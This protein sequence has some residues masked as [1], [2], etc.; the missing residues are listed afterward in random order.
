MIRVVMAG[1]AALLSLA[2]GGENAAHAEAVEHDGV[3][4]QRE[5]GAVRRYDLEADSW[6]ADMTLPATLHH[7]TAD[8]S[9][10]WV[11]ESQSGGGV[12]KAYPV[13]GGAPLWEASPSGDLV[14]ISPWLIRIHGLQLDVLDKGTGEVID[15]VEL[16]GYVQGFVADPVSRR[17]FFRFMGLASVEVGEDGALGALQ[18]SGGLVP[19][20]DLLRALPGRGVVVDEF[21]TMFD[22]ATLAYAGRLVVSSRILAVAEVG[23]EIVAHL[24]DGE[25][26]R[27]GNDLAELG[28]GEIP[29]TFDWLAP[30]NGDAVRL[31]EVGGTSV[32]PLDDLT[33]RSP[34]P[35][36]SGAGAFRPALIESGP[37]GIVLLYARGNLLRWSHADRAYL[38]GIP[39]L[40]EPKSISFDPDRGWAVIANSD[41]RISYVDLASLDPQERFLTST[42]WFN[43]AVVAGSFVVALRHHLLF[44]LDFSGGLLSE[45]QLEGLRDDLAWDPDARVLLAAR[46]GS[47]SSVPLDSLGQLGEETFREQRSSSERIAPIGDGA[48]LL[49]GYRLWDVTTL[50]DRGR[51]GVRALDARWH[52]GDLVALTTRG[53][54]EWSIDPLARQRTTVVDGEFLRL[55]PWSEGLMLV[56]LLNGRPV[57]SVI[58][59]GRDADGDGVPNPTDAFPL[60]PDRSSDRDHDGVADP[61]DAYPLDSRYSADTDADLVPDSIDFLP[62]DPAERVMRIDLRERVSL[63]KVGPF[64]REARYAQVHLLEDGTFALCTDYEVCLPGDF[65]PKGKSGRRFTLSIRPHV[66]TAFAPGL[67]DTLEPSIEDFLDR[68]IDFSLTFDPR[69]AKGLLRVEVRRGH[70]V[71]FRLKLRH[72]ATLNGGSARGVWKLSG[73]GTG[74]RVEPHSGLIGSV[75]GDAE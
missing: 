14:L 10:L 63:R 24:E 6:L 19:Y 46:T 74:I 48:H 68:E 72:F 56:R 36:D 33:P 57:F 40:G 28:R 59:P 5:G 49:K 39:L 25:T 45:T 8:R 3:V 51:I 44:V 20:Q 4:H 52:E 70:D 9:G 37:D 54:E 58:T 75:A 35:I 13:E 7:W 12:V 65:V 38:P 43:N 27:F 22:V 66:L 23:D 69:R 18:F 17:V 67:E 61:E 29:G 30:A 50:T 21:G 53:I 64:T 60:D 34:P 2:L 62:D 15:S 42:P 47:V 32:V 55:L 41:G 1:V 73:E 71:R 31:F 16:P 26:V 11:S